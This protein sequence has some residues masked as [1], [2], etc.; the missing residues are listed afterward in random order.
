MAIPTTGTSALLE[1]LS[2]YIPDLEIQAMIPRRIGG[3]RAEWSSA[4]LLRVLLLLLL[5]PARS[6]N[7]LCEL[8]PE[9]RAWRRFALLP[10]FRQLPNTRQLHEFRDRLTPSILRALNA[11]LLQ[12]IFATWPKEQPGVALIDATDLPAAINPYKKKPAWLCASG[13]P[14]WAGAR[15]RPDTR[16]TSLV[17]RSIPFGF[18]LHIIRVQSSWCR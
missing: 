14:Q 7:L 18:G 10:N 1:L 15:S 2:A 3:R 6:A 17:T 4:Q 8:L 12:R 11:V 16:G 13:R 9:Q 5:T